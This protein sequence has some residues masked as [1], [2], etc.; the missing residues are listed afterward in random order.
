VIRPA[1]LL[2]LLAA[3]LVGCAAAS[4]G[5]SLGG[6]GA[7]GTIFSGTGGAVGS[8]CLTDTCVGPLETSVVLAVEID[9]P[10]SS[11]S[12]VTQILNRDLSAPDLYETAA[13]VA[14][15]TSFA[16]PASGSV[17]ANSDVVLTVPP[18]IP[19]RPDLS[20]QSVAAPSPDNGRTVSASLSVP[21]DAVGVASTLALVP[22]PPADQTMPTYSYSM[23][24]A[25]MMA[26]ALPGDD[27]MISGQIQTGVQMPPHSTFVA[28][29]FQGSSQVSDSAL[30]GADG[31]FQVRIPSVA[32]ANPVTLQLSPV[33]Q[34]GSVAQD[35][36]F[37]STPLTVTAGKNLGAIS[38]PAYGASTTYDV[39]VALGSMG[40]PGVSVRAQATIGSATVNGT[41]IGTAS[42]VSNGG[43]AM[44]GV[45]ALSFLPGNSNSPIP[46]TVTATPPIGSTYATTCVTK[47]TPLPP[48]N[49]GGTSPPATLQTIMPA[50]R[51]VL[52]G[53]VR[54]WLGDR[55]PNVTVTA[56]GTPDASDPSCPAPAAVTATTTTDT[57]GV[58][59][60][61]LDP[62][63]Y[64]L[65]YDPPAGSSGPR[66]TEQLA[67]PTPNSSSHEVNL[68]QGAKV[69]GQVV[70][71]SDRAPVGS[72][73]VRFFLARC[74]GQADCFGPT[75]TPPLL[76][77]KALT[78]SSGN[79]RVVVPLTVVTQ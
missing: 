73:T 54:N 29:A 4:S 44:N 24:V 79:F 22:L 34:S 32:A 71:R 65:D 55:L 63:W 49:S 72:A 66:M 12:A 43:T 76:V 52:T 31:T 19:G 27:I 75:R 47:V 18:T 70:G 77:G 2:S 5:N 53:T 64:Q 16:A 28:R 58:F 57:N 38:L 41:A 7:G 51:P 10:S 50:L 46:Y 14:V 39:V 8:S 13:A 26:A 35:P 21:E 1:V 6:T 11:P 23:P 74:S 37:V 60:L 48:A 45:A 61:P 20:F 56:S 67:V 69:T 25:P 30:T 9:P 33:A 59:S 3:A 15:T 62:G 68:P 40:I 36:W 17:P 42:Y 78:D